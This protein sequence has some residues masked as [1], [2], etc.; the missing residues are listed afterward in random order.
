MRGCR[1]YLYGV[2]PRFYQLRPAS[3]REL[4]A[5][6]SV[7]VATLRVDMQF[8]GH[9]GVLQREKINSGVLDVDRIIFCLH[10]E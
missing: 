1:E 10:D 4:R 2:Q 9:S 3:H 5:A 8:C 7:A 6:Q